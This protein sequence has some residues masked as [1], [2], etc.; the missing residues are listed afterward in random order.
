MT[1]VLNLAFVSLV[2]LALIGLE[3]RV[4]AADGDLRYYFK[5]SNVNSQNPK[6][7]PM[8]KDLLEK[9]AASRPEFAENVGTAESEDARIAELRK[10]G[11][12]GYQLSMRLGPVTTEVKPPAPGH[13]DPQMAVHASLNI[14]GHTHPGGKMMFSGDGEAN[15]V[16]EFSERTREKEEKKF[17]EAALAAALKQAMDTAMVKMSHASLS[18]EGARK[19]KKGRKGKKK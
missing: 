15:L 14:F 6:L 2:F 13:K 9:E 16:G 18:T 11:M 12:K 8:A 7:I 19:G 1:K 4:N 5:I 17:I 3:A 10:Q